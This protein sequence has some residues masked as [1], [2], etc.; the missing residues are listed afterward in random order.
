MK[1]NE[2]MRGELNGKQVRYGG[3]VFLMRTLVKDYPELAPSP[4]PL[5]LIVRAVKGFFRKFGRT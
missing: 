1:N 4:S 5:T 3:A 2:I